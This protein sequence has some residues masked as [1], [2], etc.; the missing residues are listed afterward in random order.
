MAAAPGP[1]S[2]SGFLTTRTVV[3]FLVLIVTA[4]G[5]G[6]FFN[7]WWNNFDTA[8]AGQSAD[9][10]GA[11]NALFTGL[12][13]FGVLLTI[14]LQRHELALQREE[15]ELTRVELKGSKEAQ[16]HQAT[17]L[18]Q[19]ARLNALIALTTH[20]AKSYDNAITLD[21][22][23]DV[24]KNRAK[25]Y[26]GYIVR[27][28]AFVDELATKDPEGFGFLS[29]EEQRGNRPP[30]NVVVDGIGPAMSSGAQGSRRTTFRV[31]LTVT[32]RTSKNL[33]L[34]SVEAILKSR[35]GEN[36]SLIFGEAR[37][38]A[39]PPNEGTTRPNSEHAG[40]VGRTGRRAGLGFGHRE[41]CAVERT[42]AVSVWPRTRRRT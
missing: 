7:L 3:T 20:A 1:D 31:R 37:Q 5:F 15:L 36:I 10:F 19:T 24:R 40:I 9:A 22:E 4:W 12:A 11:V 39:V 35:R 41:G 17:I 30:I 16:E 26:D 8:K 14:V 42:T 27:L 18:Q 38:R 23:P 6:G 25:E 13:F 28:K 21:A 29:L 2:T 32:N 33:T 34:S